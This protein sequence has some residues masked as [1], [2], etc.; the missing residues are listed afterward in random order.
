MQLSIDLRVRESILISSLVRQSMTAR[1]SEWREKIIETMNIMDHL[2]EKSMTYTWDNHSEMIIPQCQ[3]DAKSKWE[4]HRCI[5]TFG[6][7]NTDLP[8]SMERKSHS[9]V[10]ICKDQYLIWELWS[11][12]KETQSG[13]RSIM[14]NTS[15]GLPLAPLSKSWVANSK[16]AE[17]WDSLDLSGISEEATMWGR[18]SA[19]DP[20]IIIYVELINEGR[21]I[22]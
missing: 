10:N 15:S 20:I 12:S 3:K 11:R 19:C 7:K 22:K 6:Q 2:I 4:V 16:R 21:S 14:W 8:K 1:R 9:P 13:W 18:Q 5:P 17:R